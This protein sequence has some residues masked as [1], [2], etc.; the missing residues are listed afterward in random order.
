[1]KDYDVTGE[2][3]LCRNARNYVINA[4]P[5]QIFIFT[6]IPSLASEVTF[7]RW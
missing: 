6:A 4:Y 7:E 5:A 1:M 3:G 2:I